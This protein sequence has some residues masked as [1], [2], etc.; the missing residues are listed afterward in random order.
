MHL[1]T[2]LALFECLDSILRLSACRKQTR[3]ARKRCRL[4]DRLGHSAELDASNCSDYASRRANITPRKH[5]ATPATLLTSRYAI[6]RS[7]LS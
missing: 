2:G 5:N 6:A 1:A 4:R 7:S 3:R